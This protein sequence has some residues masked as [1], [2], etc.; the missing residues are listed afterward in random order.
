MIKIDTTPNASRLAETLRETGYTINAAV[1]DIMD[2]S[3]EA[4]AQNI[5]IEFDLDDYGKTYFSITDDGIGMDKD[6]LANALTYGSDERTKPTLG[7]FGIG[8]NTASTSF[9]R[10]VLVTSRNNKK[11]P[12]LTAILDLDELG[13]KWEI[14]IIDG[15]DEDI[16]LIEGLSSNGIG[17]C[18]RWEKVDKYLDNYSTPDDP[19]RIKAHEKTIENRSGTGLRYHLACTFERLMTEKNLNVYLNGEEVEPLDIFLKNRSDNI[20]IDGEK[21]IAVEDNEGNEVESFRLIAWA[22]PARADLSPDEMKQINYKNLEQGFYI[23]REGRLL[24][25]AETFGIYQKETHKTPFRAELHF[26][27]ELDSFFVPDLKKS[28]LNPIPELMDHLEE[29]GSHYSRQAEILRSPARG[30]KRKELSKGTH[31]S[32]NKALDN[33]KL[34]LPPSPPMKPVGE[35]KVEINNKTGKGQIELK[36]VE[37]AD[38]KA[39]NIRTESD[40]KYGN[41]YEPFFD[42]KNGGAG[43][44]LNSNHEFYARVYLPKKERDPDSYLIIDY[45]LHALAMAELNYSGDTI[46]K[47]LQDIRND[48]SH[49][50]TTLAKNALPESRDE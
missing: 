14:E 20:T 17:T 45:L 42:A 22:T 46:E 43:V 5:A 18:V 23:Y 39:L 38:P 48:V 4:D 21:T 3:V 35:N 40:I 11:E 41:L 37:E 15:V 7:K 2:N 25:R 19:A 10:R 1:G 33:S 8:L 32:S 9:A 16:E 34:E 26:S 6:G 12:F 44:T 24:Q 27:K 13:E 36:I 47:V 49:R 50:L 29:F 30:K 31:T 28:K